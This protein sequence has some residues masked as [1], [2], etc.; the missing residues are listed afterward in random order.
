MNRQFKNRCTDLCT[1][2]FNLDFVFYMK[3]LEHCNLYTDS[4]FVDSFCDSHVISNKS[5]KIRETK[6]F[7]YIVLDETLAT[8]IE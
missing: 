8:H 3:A 6:L 5:M 2:R 1:D 4:E 7:N